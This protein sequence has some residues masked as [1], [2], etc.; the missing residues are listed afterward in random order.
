MVKWQLRSGRKTT[1]G[2]LR[3]HGKKEKMQR[4]RDFVP[5]RIGET[6]RY[7]MR[8][9]GGTSKVLLLAT[10]IANISVNGK[11]QRAKILS[12][13]EN[14]ADSQF[15][16]RNIIT[17]GAMIET[18]MGMARVTSRPG[19]DGAVNAVLVEEAKEKK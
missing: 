6:K 5:A 3:K 16:R 15:V 10:N 12:V 13:K 9:K 18:D 19:Q 14:P 4:G 17:S 7:A 8:G 2:L 11:V 1:G